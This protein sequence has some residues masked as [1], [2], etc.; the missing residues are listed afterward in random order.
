MTSFKRNLSAKFIFKIV[1]LFS[2]LGFFSYYLRASFNDVFQELGEISL[3]LLLLLTGLGI[4]YQYFEGKMVRG[5]IKPFSKSFTTFDGAMAAA[6]S[7][8]YRIITFGAGTIFAEIN[9]YHRKKL[10]ISQSV[11]AAIF[12]FIL[13][14]VSSLTIATIAL[15]FSFHDL[16]QLS[17]TFVWVLLVCMLINFVI[18]ALILL[19]ALSIPLQVFLVNRCHRFFKNEKVR[20]KIDQGNLQINALRRTLHEVME[21][22]SVL[23]EIYLWSLVK[24]LVWFII[25]YICLIQEHPNLNF[26]LTIS[27]ISFVTII[28]GVIPTPAGIGSFEFVYL[29]MFRSLVG[30]IDAASSLLLYRYATLLIPFVTGVIYVATIQIK[31]RYMNRKSNH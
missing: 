30:T 27:L 1:I 19:A 15:I 29:I 4:L 25:P 14:K 21:D 28:S 8:F 13:F 9:F 6:Y 24:I 18:C 17:P 20:Q 22:I 12:R 3:W 26:F 23:I 2:L 16:Y 11:G 31:S 10:T 7:A 5:T